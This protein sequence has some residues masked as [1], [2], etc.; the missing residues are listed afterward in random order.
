MEKLLASKQ[1]DVKNTQRFGLIDSTRLL[2]ITEE[3]LEELQSASKQLITDDG[4]FQILRL[5]Q[6]EDL[7]T[8]SQ[9]NRSQPRIL[10]LTRI[11]LQ[12]PQKWTI[13]MF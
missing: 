6:T 7:K 2:T 4:A 10:N 11:P 12:A 1:H 3:T 8:R 5:K 9:L 13:R